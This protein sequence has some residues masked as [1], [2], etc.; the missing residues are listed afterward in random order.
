LSFWHAEN[1]VEHAANAASA[2]QTVQEVDPASGAQAPF[3][4]TG[5]AVFKQ[6]SSVVRRLC[7]VGVPAL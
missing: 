3:P 5:H 7:A 2:S 4:V 6:L 1:W